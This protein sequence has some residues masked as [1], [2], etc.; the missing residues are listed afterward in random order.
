M[1]RTVEEIGA[2]MDALGLWEA[3]APYNWA[4][5]PRGT[6]L[7]YFCTVVLG[8]KGSPLKARFLMLE[9]WQTMHDYVHTR[10][11]RNYGYYSSPAEMPHLEMIFVSGGQCKLFR[12]DTGF[13]PQEAD[14]RWRDLAE[15]LL[16]ESFGVMM[17]IENDRQLPMKYSDE[18]AIFARVE[19]ASGEWADAPLP[20]PDCPQIGEKVSFPQADLKAAQALLPVAQGEAISVDFRLLDGVITREPR[21]R[22]IYELVATGERQ[23]ELRVP[24]PSGCSLRDMW[25]GMP[26]QVLKA[27]IRRGRVPGEIRLVSGRVFRL[28]RPLCEE[29]PFKLSLHDD[30]PELTLRPGPRNSVGV[31]A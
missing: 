8:E 12:Y 17:R 16:W 31:Q 21:P 13:Q 15:K 27:L 22:S 24:I 5:K 18:R 26:A 2:K 10:V 6:A 9:G 29:L 23:L 3:V 1:S 20:I 7:P 14:A 25:V 11:D 19:S 30:L 4:V 28:L